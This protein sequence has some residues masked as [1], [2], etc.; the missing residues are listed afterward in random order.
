MVSFHADINECEADPPL[1]APYAQCTDSEG[2]YTCAC[3]IGFQGDGYNTCKDVNECSDV[4]VC[5]EEA[6][7]I[8]TE[9]SYSC[10]CEDGYEGDGLTCTGRCESRQS[11]TPM[12]IKHG[13][14][15]PM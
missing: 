1:C 4:R 8:N 3:G 12:N 5:A 9:G 10:T 7:C 6:V 13:N 11:Q 2:S 15:Y 14:I